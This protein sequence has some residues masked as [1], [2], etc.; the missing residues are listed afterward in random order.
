MIEQAGWRVD[1]PEPVTALPIPAPGDGS[2]Q[3]LQIQLGPPPETG[4]V[5][6]VWLRG[7]ESP[8]LTSVHL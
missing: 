3:T 2:K 5:L 1:N 7:E 8:R 4:A 6:N